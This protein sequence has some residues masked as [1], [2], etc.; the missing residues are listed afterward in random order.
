MTVIGITEP[1][2]HGIDLHHTRGHLVRAVMESIAFVLR[3]IAPELQAQDRQIAAYLLTHLDEDGF[4]TIAPF[5]VARY[6]HVLVERVQNII[7]LIQRCEPVGV[8]SA[9]AQ[10]SRPAII[11]WSTS[12]RPPSNPKAMRF[13]IRRRA[14]SLRPATV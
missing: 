5:E 7:R 3:Q 12:H 4:L 1:A 11:K 13:P 9:S 2:F 8:G 10:C 14:V 6:F